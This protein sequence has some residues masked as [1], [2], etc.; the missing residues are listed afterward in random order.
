MIRDIFILVTLKVEIH[1]GCLTINRIPSPTT[2]I[3]TKSEI[4]RP[5]SFGEN[6]QKQSDDIVTSKSK[7]ATSK[8]ITLSDSVPFLGVLNTSFEVP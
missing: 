6:T 7:L 2:M 3:C 4:N 1:N 8:S 5:N